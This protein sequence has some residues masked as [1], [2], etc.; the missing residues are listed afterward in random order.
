MYYTKMK[1]LS[2]ITLLLLM[3]MPLG[4][5]HAQKI[6][7]VHKTEKQETVFGIAKQYG[8]TI[9]ELRDANPAMREENFMLKKGMLI[10]IPEHQGNAGN[11]SS[12]SKANVSQTTA[13]AKDNGKKAK[14]DKSITIG[15]M[16]PLHDI[17]GDGRRMV[18]YYRGML[19]AINEL[20]RDGVN[21]TINTWNLAEGDD[22]RTTL[23]DGRAANCDIIFGP[24]YTTQVRSL[25]DYCMQHNIRLVIPFSIN[26]NDVQTC[27][28]IY[29]VYQTPADI[30]A[31]CIE[32]FA[33][34][35]KDC[36]PV[37]IDCNDTSSKK[38]GFTFGLRKVLEEKGIN[39]SITNLNNSPAM[40]MQA[41]SPTK[42]NVVVL[43]TGRSPELGQVFKKMEEMVA[44]APQLKISMFGYNEWFLYTSVYDQKFR[45]FDTY[46]PSTYDYDSKSS[47]VQNIEK[48]YQNYYHTTVQLALPRFAIT[49]YDHT[50]FFVRGFL[51]YGKDFHGFDT[52]K[53]YTPVQTP[54]QFQRIGNGGYQNRSF[55][56]IHYK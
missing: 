16:L 36:H 6:V 12:A 43:N 40:F 9:D 17:N 51:K 25:A 4:N 29:Q 56:L 50:M 7:T 53:C 14:T 27:P 18:E 13:T 49:G 19:L 34:Q 38:G 44:Y 20:K 52:Q 46:I 35:F 22:A 11:T 32:T 33:G 5:I 55:M 23:F 3:M 8:V 45:K 41:F 48:L 31:K 10:N 39:Y 2:A 30:D 26:G 21:V 37:F 28:N 47:R 1:V 54:L 24:L 42:R 15:I